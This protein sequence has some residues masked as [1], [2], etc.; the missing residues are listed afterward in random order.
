MSDIV[1]RVAAVI[2]VLVVARLIAMGFSH[3]V[4]PSH[5]DVIV[6]EVGERPG[7]VMF[8]ATDCSTCKDAIQRLRDLGIRFREVTYELEPQRF[9]TWQVGAVPVTVIV[10]ADATVVSVISGVPSVKQ[11]RRDIARAGIEVPA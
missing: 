5:P 2:V 4:R 11:I 10:D 8:T 1:I 6:G 9:D 3:F 7:V